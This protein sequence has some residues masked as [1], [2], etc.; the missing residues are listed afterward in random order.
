[1]AYMK[2]TTFEYYSGSNIDHFLDDCFEVDEAIAPV[3]RELNLKG[4]TTMFCCSGH[5]CKDRCEMIYNDC[6]TDPRKTMLW[7][8]AVDKL[9]DGENNYRIEFDIPGISLY[10]K[11]KEHYDF[12][13]I[14]NEFEYEDG[15]LDY[16]YDN[17]EPYDFLYERLTVCE[18]LYEWAK[19][20]P[21][22][23]KQ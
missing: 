15:V 20:L 23:S 22:R 1:M 8:V 6:T 13:Q 5:P 12:E 19:Q 21:E 10:I 11:F 18:R 14:P 4:Y 2:K 9:P 16:I 7:I 17:E 3:I